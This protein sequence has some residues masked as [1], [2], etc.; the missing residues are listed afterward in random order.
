MMIEGYASRMCIWSRMRQ[1]ALSSRYARARVSIHHCYNRSISSTPTTRFHFL[2][3]HFHRCQRIPRVHNAC[4]FR[5]SFSSQSIFSSSKA[6]YSDKK[7]NNHKNRNSK[8]NN[9]TDLVFYRR[10]PRDNRIPRGNLLFCGIHTSYW[11]WYASEC[12]QA[13]VLESSTASFYLH[14]TAG[15]YGFT[16]AM[17]LNF[18][19]YKYSTL[20]V[21]KMAYS[22]SSGKVKV[23]LHALP[24]LTEADTPVEFELGEVFLDRTKA[25]VIYLL[26]KLGGDMTEFRGHL[27]LMVQANHFSAR[28]PLLVYCNDEY[29][30]KDNNLFLD[31]LLFDVVMENEDDDDDD[32]QHSNY[33][34][35][36]ADQTRLSSIEQLRVPSKSGR[37][38]Q[39]KKKQ[40]SAKW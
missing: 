28:F 12:V 37:Q 10:N 32:E 2:R 24:F 20:I 35:S 31:A 39:R 40:R 36:G 18:A 5:C 9:N 19:C 38:S 30:V 23:W 8:S 13:F 14:P 15:M 4:A 34:E 11:T 29:V 25:E 22:E 6:D 16:F 3:E 21:S 7:I 26:E 1:Q 17:M 33:N 27:P